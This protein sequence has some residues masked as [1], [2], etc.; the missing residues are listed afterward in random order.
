MGERPE[1][2]SDRVRCSRNDGIDPDNDCVA[3]RINGVTR[4]IRIYARNP[5]AVVDFGV[6]PDAN[7]SHLLSGLCM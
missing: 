3:A 1:Y 6:D 4:I 5:P 2:G 7:G